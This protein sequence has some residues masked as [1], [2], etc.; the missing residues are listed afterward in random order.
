MSVGAFILTMAVE[1][2]L[3]CRLPAMAEKMVIMPMGAHSSG[4]I[5]RPSRMPMVTFS[6]WVLPLFSAPQ[7]SP[8]AV[9]SF[10]FSILMVQ[11]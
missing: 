5:I 2:P 8:F 3:D 1:N 9:F 4:R 10:R 6:T 11:R 7:K